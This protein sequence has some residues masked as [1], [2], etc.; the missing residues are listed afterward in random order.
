MDCRN[1]PLIS[2]N[3]SYLLNCANPQLS[4]EMTSDEPVA[5]PHLKALGRQA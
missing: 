3:M 5:Q 4:V 2:L 1:N